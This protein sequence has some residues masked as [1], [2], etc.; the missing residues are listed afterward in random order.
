MVNC[1]QQ[2]FFVL[3]CYLSDKPKIFSGNS[4][5]SFQYPWL[6]SLISESI[7]AQLTDCN[8]A[9]EIWHSV[10]K[11]FGIRSTPKT[12]QYKNQTENQKKGLLMEHLAKTELLALDQSYCYSF[13]HYLKI[14]SS[15]H[16]I[17]NCSSPCTRTRAT[18]NTVRSDRTLPSVKLS[19]S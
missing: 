3:A 4:K 13:C 15:V 19:Q 16:P 1:K 17:C 5:G 12:M 18:R 8:T 11:I 2:C 10:E 14:K 6:L 9:E 7:L